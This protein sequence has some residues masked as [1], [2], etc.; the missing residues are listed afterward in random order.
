[1]LER[2]LGGCLQ[3]LD[4]LEIMKNILCWYLAG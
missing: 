1:M 4:D 2:G 3:R